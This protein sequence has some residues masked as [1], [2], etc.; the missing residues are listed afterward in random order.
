MKAILLK[1]SQDWI[2]NPNRSPGGYK[3]SQL[4][5]ALS[6]GTS[7]SPIKGLPNCRD[8]Q[9]LVGKMDPIMVSHE[10]PSRLSP[11]ID[12]EPLHNQ[13]TKINRYLMLQYKILLKYKEIHGNLFWLRAMNF[14]LHSKSLRLTALRKVSP[15]WHREIPLSRVKRYL[16]L[17]DR[18][19][20]SLSPKLSL[21]RLWIKKENGDYRPLG[22]PSFTDRLFLNLLQNLLV[23]FFQDTNI[24]PPSQHAY[25]PSK[26]TQTCWQEL[27]KHLN[28]SFIKEFDLSK[29]FDKVQPTSFTMILREHK[30][31]QQVMDFFSSMNI[32]NSVAP[33]TKQRDLVNEFS[34]QDPAKLRHDHLTQVRKE[35]GLK[36]RLGPGHGQVLMSFTLED[37][38]LDRD[39]WSYRPSQERLDQKAGLPQGSS[40]S[41]IAAIAVF[42]RVF[43]LPKNYTVIQYADDFIV[44]SNRPDAN[45]KLTEWLRI[46]KSVLNQHGISINESK[47]HLLK[48]SGEWKV[49]SFKFL[50]VTYETKT[51]NLI[52]TPRSG[53]I[54][55][56]TDTN[57]RMLLALENREINLAKVIKVLKLVHGIKLTGSEIL[58][59]WAQDTM[60]IPSLL[61]SSNYLLSTDKISAIADIIAEQSTLNS[62]LEQSYE[63]MAALD[64]IETKPSEAL[65]AYLDKAS[66][67][68]AKLDEYHSNPKFAQLTRSATQKLI[69]NSRISELNI[70]TPAEKDYLECL[71]TAFSIPTELHEEYCKTVFKMTQS[72]YERELEFT[73]PKHSYDGNNMLRP[74]PLTDFIENIPTKWSKSRAKGIILSRLYSSKEVKPADTTLTYKVDSWIGLYGDTVPKRLTIHNSSTYSNWSAMQYL[75]GKIRWNR[76]PSLRST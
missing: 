27:S 67:A 74:G 60:G 48:M 41:P 36:H 5:E 23:I 68:R 39:E 11:H 65:S 4:R 59:H 29:F 22:I 73:V 3:P 34:L 13:Q 38:G 2:I 61:V 8:F 24:L 1:L 9:V 69:A 55:V 7:R 76:R 21:R 62:P 53:E 26:G 54:N 50:G 52:G 57:I 70:L 64:N 43:R 49:D 6:R 47:S 66:I 51:G 56:L 17:L 10:M 18:R 44:T 42:S 33:T 46:N 15:N 32:L 35:S 14:L 16:L 28:D 75:T 37:L 58:K 19:I 45:T 20:N 63:Q 72:E 30:T 31:P 25:Q 12:I 40:T 71:D